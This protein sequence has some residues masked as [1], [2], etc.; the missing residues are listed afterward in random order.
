MAPVVNYISLTNRKIYTGG[1]NCV[2]FIIDTIMTT[3]VPKDTG[4]TDTGDEKMKKIIG[5]VPMLEF[6][7]FTYFYF[8]VLDVNNL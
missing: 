4:D 3:G 6:S 2:R 1:H 8:D 7:M 5:V